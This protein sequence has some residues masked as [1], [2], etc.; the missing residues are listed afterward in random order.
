MPP[1]DLPN[2]FAAPTDTA[3]A[4]LEE[5]LRAAVPEKRFRHSLGVAGEAR[6]MA[7][8]FGADPVRARL[9]GLLHDCAKGIP[10]AEQ[11]AT[12]DR[13]GV[14]LDAETRAC[15]PVVHGF[16]GAHLAR[17]LYGVEDEAVLGAI[18]LHTVGGEGMTLLEK[19]VYLADATE[20]GRDFPGVEEVRGAAERSV[21]EGLRAF[22]ATQL[23]RFAEV[24]KPF[25]PGMI[26][27]WNELVRP[28]A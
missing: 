25:H 8:R 28:R 7:E 18:R 6:R 13:L 4:A 27:L 20:P 1:P 21:D 16:L 26:R 3:W 10:V 15:P 14:A 5:K 12:C 2:G 17:T 24:G 9:A 11:V 22:I 23:R 19:I